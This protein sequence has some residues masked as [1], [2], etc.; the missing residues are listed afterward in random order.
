MGP[1]MFQT[2]DILFLM[3]CH[4][5]FVGVHFHL[6]YMCCFHVYFYLDNFSPEIYSL[7][8]CTRCWH[9]IPVRWI[10]TLWDCGTLKCCSPILVYSTLTGKVVIWIDISF[11]WDSPLFLAVSMRISHHV[12][13]IWYNSSWVDLMLSSKAFPRFKLIASS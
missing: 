10:S 3:G 5:Q 7:T 9:P 11:D 1:F 2:W 12:Y 6:G 8:N 13:K 4:S